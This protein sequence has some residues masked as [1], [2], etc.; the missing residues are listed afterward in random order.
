[1]VIIIIGTMSGDNGH[2]LRQAKARNCVSRVINWTLTRLL[3]TS[4]LP[5]L[6]GITATGLYVMGL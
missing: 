2:K 4:A 1:M 3:A 5:P 6:D